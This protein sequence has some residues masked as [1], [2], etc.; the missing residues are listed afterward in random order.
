M[1]RF[2]R[3][4]YL[5]CFYC[6][7]RPGIKFD[8]TFRDFLCLHCDATNYLDENGEITDP[9]VA[10]EHEAAA[11]QYAA[12]QSPSPSETDGIFCQTCLKNQHLFTKS[13]A[14]YLPDD[15][16]D[17]DYP[18]LERNYYRYRRNLEKRYPQVCSD[19]AERVEGRI[20]QAGYTAKTD[21]LRRMMSL[22]RGRRTRR[23]TPLDWVNTLGKT[24]WRT[25]F[26]LQMLWHFVMMTQSLQQSNDGMY[27]PDDQSTYA[28]AISWLKLAIGF[29]PSAATLI[30][31]SIRTAILAVWWNPH[32]VQVN[33][34][35]T[36]HLLG[37]TQWYSFQGLTIFFR[38]IFRGVVDANAQ[39]AGSGTAKLSAHVAMAVVMTL[40][41]V[42]AGKSI[43]VDTSPLFATE[44]RPLVSKEAK[45][46]MQRRR[47]D[48]K[49]FSEL[50]ND[51]LDSANATPQKSIMTDQ[52]P[53]P[54]SQFSPLRPQSSL[55]PVLGSMRPAETP[56]KRT[57]QLQYDEEMDWSPVAS[58]HR[59]LNDNS[60]PLTSKFGRMDEEALSSPEAKNP[61]WCKVPAAPV[62]PAQRLRNPH[63]SPA[64]KQ[65][66]PAGTGKVMFTRRG[67]QPTSSQTTIGSDTNG[68][69][70]FKQPRFFAPQKDHDASSLADLL[71]QSFTLG[72]D[73]EEENAE[74]AA[75]KRGSTTSAETMPQ[76]SVK[77]GLET[78]VLMVLLSAWLLAMFAHVP[79]AW[80]VRLTTLFVA[81]V[82]ALRR[83]GDTSHR[84]E[85]RI[86]GPAAYLLSAL[87]AAELAAI[88]W[89][90]SKVWSGQSD[91]IGP[92]G[93]GVLVSMLG[94]QVLR[95]VL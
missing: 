45:S 59:A 78:T 57:E 92:Y 13:L 75:E 21:H 15:P 37:F 81:G 43:R 44:D 87:G 53:S 31:W 33:R 7:K 18:E 54:Q 30:K 93:V 73:Q 23:R 52:A 20:R 2:G 48:S 16:T 46:P 28:T 86:P 26:V 50:V 27:D 90:G 88:C 89:V 19:C 12:Q 8:G 77:P 42:L 10:T 3:A 79:Y 22:S 76:T 70:E 51:A 11:V 56:T 72:Q 94:H 71:S 91:Q 55:R 29:L 1:A 17:P 84:I 85:K 82:V 61:F 47:D 41:Y 95:V 74:M 62:N 38:F 66:E 69:V 58:Q 9:P 36:R 14:Q 32:F 49:T 68:G 24:L 64:P 67:H 4:K 34:G 60:T 40:I 6:G 5:T 83:T 65:Q 35:F 80:E 25:G 39:T 63:W